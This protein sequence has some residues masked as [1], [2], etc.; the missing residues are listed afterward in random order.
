MNSLR[1]GLNWYP[2]R[3]VSVSRIPSGRSGRPCSAEVFPQSWLLVFVTSVG[4]APRMRLLKSMDTEYERDRG[5]SKKRR[6]GLLPIRVAAGQTR[7]RDERRGAVRCGRRGQGFIL[8]LAQHGSQLT[9]MRRGKLPRGHS[10]GGSIGHLTTK[11]AP[12]GSSPAYG[13][14]EKNE[15]PK[16]GKSLWQEQRR[17]NCWHCREFFVWFG[18]GTPYFPW[19]LAGSSVARPCEK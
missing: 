8:F 4:R 19:A 10:M 2:S 6:Q 9:S 12:L 14:K 15:K 18:T 7:C 3:G 13:K 11:F 17:P 1:N 16:K 5:H